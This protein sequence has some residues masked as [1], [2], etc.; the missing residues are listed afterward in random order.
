MENNDKNSERYKKISYNKNLNNKSDYLNVSSFLV[1]GVAAGS[2]S[3]GCWVVLSVLNSFEYN[4]M[5]ELCQC[6]DKL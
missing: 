6:C 3:R 1:M 2:F 5:A 4:D